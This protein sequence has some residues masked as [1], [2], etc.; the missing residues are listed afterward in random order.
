MSLHEDISLAPH[1]AVGLTDTQC[2]RMYEEMATARKYDERAHVLQ[3]AGKVAFH[4]SGIGHEVAQ[5]AAATA[6]DPQTDL[7]FPYYRDYALLLS[8]GM[9]LRELMLA[10]FLKADDPNSGGRQ[11][12]GHFGCKRLRVFTGSSPVAT[13]IPHAVGAA[14]ATKLRGESAVSFVSFGEGSS[15]QGDFHEGCNFAGVH[16]LPVILFCENNRYAISVPEKLQIA[17]RVV[18]RAQGY[19]FAGVRV[20][21]NDP[22]AVYDAVRQARARAVAGEGPTLIEAMMYRLQPHSTA[23]NDL[24]YRTQAEIDAHRAVD[25]VVHML[26]YVM[27]QGL[28]TEEQ[29]LQWM[30]MLDEQL[31]QAIEEADAAPYPHPATMMHHIYGDEA[32]RVMPGKGSLS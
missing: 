6:L 26:H 27:Q 10:L 9:T 32:T 25:G 3:R 7:F 18:D 16:R 22:F 19:G 4:V 1:R 2:V 15:N 24:L 28:R 21:G 13:Q 8:I 17:G 12:V 11:M 5:V 23:D 20:D 29:Q 31:R 14:Y 30:G